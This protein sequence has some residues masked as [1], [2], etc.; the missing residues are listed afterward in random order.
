VLDN[1]LPGRLM[2]YAFLAAAVLLAVFVRDLRLAPPRRLAGLALLGAT[3]V[4]LLPRMPFPSA[5]VSTPA[6]FTTAA[7]RRIGEGDVVLVAPFSRM[8]VPTEAMVWQALSGMRFRMPEG[9]YQGPGPGRTRI[10]GP[11]PSATSA[12]MEEIWSRGTA[13]PLDAALRARIGAELR[14]WGVRDVLVGPMGHEELMT[15]VMTSLLGRGPERIGGVALW[16]DV[17]ATAVRSSPTPTTPG[18]APAPR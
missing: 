3:A 4:T 12:L 17:D 14:A 16:A 10:Y 8:P 2:L 11:P 1:L 15:A 6:F 9:Y 18:S 7:V 13:P 5:P